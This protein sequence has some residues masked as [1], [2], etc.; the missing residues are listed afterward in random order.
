MEYLVSLNWDKSVIESLPFGCALPIQEF[1][2]PLKEHPPKDWTPSAY[3]LIGREDLVSTVDPALI[4]EET[5]PVPVLFSGRTQAELTSQATH[6]TESLF[7]L[8]ARPPLKDP[9]PANQRTLNDGLDDVFRALDGARFNRDNRLKQVRLSVQSMCLFAYFQVRQSLN[10]TL[11][12]E[13]IIGVGVTAEDEIAAMIQTKLQALVLRTLATSIGRGAFSLGTVTSSADE[14]NVGPP[15]CLTGT[16]PDQVQPIKL[17]LLT[18]RINHEIMYFQNNSISG[19]D[20]EEAKKIQ[21]WPEFHNA[22]STALKMKPGKVKFFKLSKFRFRNSI[23]STFFR[24][25]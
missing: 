25:C 21:M 11:P 22:V 9:P 4:E 24:N 17:D 7:P 13:I 14:M 20:P 19:V 3:V 1:I 18:N 6:Q 2:R 10:T 8:L 12:Q 5:P 23:Y 15:L 16:V